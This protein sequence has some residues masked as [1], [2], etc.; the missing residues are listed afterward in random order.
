MNK[1]LY[2]DEE[3]AKVMER[4]NGFDFGDPKDDDNDKDEIEPPQTNLYNS[5]TNRNIEPE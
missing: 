3:F 1:W 2:D 5:H 4:L